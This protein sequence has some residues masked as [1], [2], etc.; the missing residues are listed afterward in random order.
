MA[1]LDHSFGGDLVFSGVG[2]YQTVIGSDLGRQRVLR[3]LLTTPGE[4]IFHPNYGAGI[5]RFIGQPASQQRIAALV[6]AQMFQEAAVARS[7]PPTI[8]VTI[9]SDD[10]VQIN[11]TYTDADTKA[12]VFLQVAVT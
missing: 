6:R 12:P 7:P 10:T 4:Y 9:N 1:D 8:V 3:R 2:G 5:T 11:I